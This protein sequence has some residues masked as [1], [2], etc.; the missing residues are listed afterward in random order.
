M[1]ISIICALFVG[2]AF[3]GGITA[4]LPIMRV[5]LNN[6]T[7]A[8][9]AN[10]QIAEKRL[11]V[12]LSD[13]TAD[14]R[15]LRVEDGSPADRAGLKPTDI[16]SAETDTGQERRNKL[17]YLADP[18]VQQATVADKL[19]NLEPAPAYLNLSGNIAAKFPERPLYA[20]AVAF[21]IIAVITTIGNV[22]RF[23]QE[24]LADRAAILAVR[25]IRRHLYDHVLHV[26]MSFFGQ[27][28]TSDVTSR[29][30]TDAQGLQEGFRLVLGQSIQ[31]PIKVAFAL[32]LALFLSWKLTL[33]IVL[34]GPIMFLII[35]KFG[36]KMRRA[37]REAMAKSSSMLGQIEGT[38]IGIRVVKGANAERFERRRYAGI[39]GQ[40]SVEQ[41][42]MSR[43]DALSSPIIETLSL[44][45]I[46]GVVL[47][48]SYLVLEAHTL[49]KT[50]F[51]LVMVCLGG[52]G[53]SLRRTSKVNNLLQRSN[54]A[55]TRIFETIDLPSEKSRTEE[56]KALPRVRLKPITQE[57]RF[58]NI[59]F[60]YPGATTP[61]LVDV[62]L[63]VPK[64]KSVAV[65]GRNGSGK[66]TLLALLPRFYDP[67]LGRVSIDGVDVRN[68]T[69]NSLRDQISLVTQDSVIFPG[70]VAENVAYGHP[71]A[72]LLRS[73]TPRA[74]ATTRQLRAD[75]ENAAK[76]AFAHEFILEKNGGYDHFLDGLGGGLSGG[77][78]QRLNIA[79]A[80]LRQSPIL[81]LDE[82]T[83]Q[84][85]AES[86]HLIQQAI[87]SLMHERT[88]F[89]IAHRFSTIMSAD[90]IVVMD[91]GRI[92]GQ[93]KH[94]ELLETC[95]TYAQLY[96]RQLFG[97]TG[98]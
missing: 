18:S 6:Q 44:F 42:R 59:S 67:T 54:A 53:E 52:I 7:V 76:R 12:Q 36:K 71:L 2:V 20:I 4:M 88:T 5:L 32:G 69:R 73:T 8:E 90:T 19:V 82:A 21:G 30:V 96:E 65:V 13:D 55:A 91:K 22:I 31:E 89:V 43:Y 70:T 39:M 17:K 86:E 60:T 77:Q 9:W 23:F 87:E 15:V 49:E 57:V 62:S 14:V 81:I 63:A 98:A 40:L 58:E 75:V 51:F 93:G 47:F 79:R 10:G 80:I 25:D 41:L 34:F 27:K 35:K 66:T 74:L 46:G 24:Y 38:L 83:S 33:F 45:V 3:T 61:A 37:S 16:V 84:V 97:G 72:H 78:K 1:I 64:G 29:L 85:D 56:E 11:G 92:V 48:A 95:K 68:V 26:P 50:T 94:D 28:G